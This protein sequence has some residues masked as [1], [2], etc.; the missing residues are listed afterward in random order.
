MSIP[1]TSTTSFFRKVQLQKNSDASPFILA[2]ASE[3]QRRA[4]KGGIVIGVVRAR[5]IPNRM[6]CCLDHGIIPAGA[7]LV[8]LDMTLST[9]GGALKAAGNVSLFRGLIAE[10]FWSLVA[11]VDAFGI[12]HLTSWR[13]QAE[14]SNVD[15]GTQRTAEIMNRYRAMVVW[16]KN[17]QPVWNGQGELPVTDKIMALA[18]TMMVLLGNESDLRTYAA[19]VVEESVPTNNS[20]FFE[21]E[22]LRKI[23]KLKQEGQ[24][25]LAQAQE[26]SLP[27]QQP[28]TTKFFT[29]TIAERT[30]GIQGNTTR[31]YRRNIN[32]PLRDDTK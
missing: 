11:H 7:V 1:T 17:N 24:L 21:R 26:F 6:P 28:E 12:Q 14:R 10:D 3:A 13:C 20:V 15:G 18:H 27:Q 32:G 30:Q 31:F 19:V 8:M 16:W 2:S 29:Q 4:A 22:V 9:W 5:G 23:E 25:L